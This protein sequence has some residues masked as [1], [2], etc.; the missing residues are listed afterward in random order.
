MT[1]STTCKQVEPLLDELVD[2]TLDDA[3]A[4][5]ARAHL[6]ECVACAASVEALESLKTSA[7]G[8]GALEPPPELWQSISARLDA[9]LAD[10]ERR[11]RLWWWW[12]AWRRA[13]FAG[14]GA[15][16]AAGVAAALWLA[17]GRVP[18]APTLAALPAPPVSAASLY[19]QAVAEVMRAE[20]D[21]TDAIDELRQVALEE[22]RG[23]S[24]DAAR[25]FDDNLAAIDA[26]IARQAEAFRGKPGDPAT[27]DALH[28]MYRKKI[29]FLQEAVM[30]GSL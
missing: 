12:H 27:T 29:D 18:L 15:L 28:A 3:R 5:A 14:G 26:A 30:R 8:L 2:G 6:R 21:Y 4:R 13:I 17:G 9:T 25:A 24:P 10:E 22:R 23:W 16:A 19:D 7:A 20:K 1:T 11:P